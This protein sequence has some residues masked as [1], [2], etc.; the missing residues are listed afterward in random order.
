VHGPSGAVVARAGGQ[1]IKAGTGTGQ[2][3]FEIVVSQDA[4]LPLRRHIREV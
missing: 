1:V 4:L 3:D 2:A